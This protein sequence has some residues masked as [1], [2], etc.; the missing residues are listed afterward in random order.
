MSVAAVAHFMLRH[1]PYAM[2]VRDELVGYLQVTAISQTSLSRMPRL[3]IR[4]RGYSR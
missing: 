4:A 1:S 2:W 3:R